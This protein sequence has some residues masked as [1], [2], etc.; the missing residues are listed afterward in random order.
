MDNRGLIDNRGPMGIRPRVRPVAAGLA[1]LC[2]APLLGACGS[3]SS[4]SGSGGPPTKAQALAYGAV[5]NLRP[6]DLPGFKSS[7]NEATTSP[8]RRVDAEVASC[9]GGVPPGHAVAEVGSPQFEHEANL[10]HQLVS[11]E[12]TVMP[13]AALAMQ[14]LNAI[15][16]AKGQECIKHYLNVLL[17]DRVKTAVTIEG[18]SV[19]ALPTQAPGTDGAFG[20]QMSMTVT[21]GGAQFPLYLDVMGFVSSSA[22][23]TL[24]AGGL[25]QPFPQASE[26]QL[27]SL[28]VSR[29]SAHSI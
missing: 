23:V 9:A 26:K 6:A 28:L 14:N 27:F 5:V 3:G 13:T 10:A 8:E 17:T 15:K 20:M 24:M 7:P 19:S 18:G 16:S 2:A 4:A 12:V 29:A 1:L 22:E 21:G 25:P 11:S